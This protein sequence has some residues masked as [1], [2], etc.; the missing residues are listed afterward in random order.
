MTATT[1]YRVSKYVT[2]TAIKAPV[3]LVTAANVTT[4]N[5]EQTIETVALVEGDRVL[6]AAQTDPIENGLWC[7]STSAWQR[8]DDWDG[9]RD[10]VDGTLVVSAQ[11]GQ[12][13]LW[14]MNTAVDPFVPGEDACTFALL[15]YADLAARLGSTA[16]GDGASLVA[17]EDALAIFAGTDV[18]SVLAEIQTGWLADV[19][20]IN[21]QKSVGTYKT[22]DQ[23]FTSSLVADDDELQVPIQSAGLWRV[24]ALIY[25]SLDGGTK[26]QGGRFNFRLAGGILTGSDN[27]M[28]Y[29]ASDPNTEVYYRSGYT[30]VV[31]DQILD[32]ALITQAGDQVLYLNGCVE[33]SAAGTL[34]F[35]FGK[36]TGGNDVTV[37]TK[38]YLMATKLVD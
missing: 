26:T 37:K 4:L 17:V 20:T 21:A 22:I 2:G 6:L 36:A 30:N 10:A 19:A 25:W 3:K 5:G 11:V 33:M 14:Q 31:G 38:S 23:T 35:R 32:G 18:E 15:N 8:P 29:H 1:K 34:I 12:E 27:R 9:V 24:E 13:G 16:N 28:W 7:V